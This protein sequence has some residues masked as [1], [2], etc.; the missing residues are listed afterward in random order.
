MASEPGPL[1][2]ILSP[3]LVGGL[4]VDASCAAVLEAWRDKKLRPAVNRDLLVRYVGLWRAMG[5]PEIQIRRWSWWFTA[6]SAVDFVPNDLSIQAD[7]IK[8]CSELAIRTG[9]SCVVHRGAISVEGTS[10][11]W[12]AASD[13]LLSLHPIR[14]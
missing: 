6:P 3:D 9:A 4:W 5:L 7:P 10:V 2:V 13:F 12:V 11:Q 14:S 8:C 1:R